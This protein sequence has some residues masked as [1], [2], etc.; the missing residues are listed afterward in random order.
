[1]I[2]LAGMGTQTAMRLVDATR[3]RQLELI[4]SSARHSRAISTFRER[5]G[6]IQSVEDL[7][8]DQEVYTFVMR[9]FDLE[10]QI[11]GK[12][13]IGKI[14][15]SDINDRKA[16]VNRLTDPRFRELHISMGF[17]DAGAK[18]ANTLDPSWQEAIVD[19]YVEQRFINNQAEQNEA[20]GIALEFR[21]A[22]PEV[23]TWLDVLKDKGHATFMRT[24]LGIP[25]QVAQLDIDKQAELF[26]KKFDI[27]K[28]KDPAE[29]EALVRKYTAISDALDGSAVAG[30][31]AVQMMTNLASGA[32]RRY[33][34]ITLDITAISA[35]PSAP[36]R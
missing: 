24:A 34:P 32:S 36:Y 12:A 35:K 25:E 9:A 20:V 19:R 5:I 21:R 13:M 3:D 27:A 31:A 23:K 29:V 28:L 10:D 6:D 8:D 1:M 14:L 22:A 7:L 15:E 33:V 2:P 4:E 30:N 16:L 11:F 17:T 26:A 18:N